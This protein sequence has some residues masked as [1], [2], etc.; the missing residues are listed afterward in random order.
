MVKHPLGI[1][2]NQTDTEA[3]QVPVNLDTANTQQNEELSGAENRAPNATLM[4]TAAVKVIKKA[5]QKKIAKKDGPKRKY[6]RRKNVP[7]RFINASD[8]K[9]AD[10]PVIDHN[11]SQDDDS[12]MIIEP[13]PSV[14]K[15]SAVTYEECDS[16][17]VF[18]T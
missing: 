15:L 16:K 7:Y 8:K 17:K 13:T 11:A 5:Q 9:S 6:T 18:I 14:R 12:V 2:T 4:T 10:E 3:Q 1:S